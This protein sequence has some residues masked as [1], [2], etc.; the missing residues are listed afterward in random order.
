M[1]FEVLVRRKVLSAAADELNLT[2]STLSYQ[3]KSLEHYFDQR[4]F[5]RTREGFELTEYGATI[6]P[7]VRDLLKSLSELGKT[8]NAAR[9]Q[10]RVAC[11]LSIKVAWLIPRLRD[12]TEANPQ[13]D[14]QLI[15][16]RRN[17]LVKLGEA[18]VVIQYSEAVYGSLTKP[19]FLAE[20]VQVAASP[21]F[22]KKHPI[23]KPHD[24]LRVPLIINAMTPWTP[25]LR[26][27][28]IELP[29]PRRGTV[30]DSAVGVVEGAAFGIGAALI[31]EKIAE[32][33]LAEGRLVS[34]FEPLPDA[35]SYYVAA[36][37]SA[38]RRPEVKR[39][40]NWIENL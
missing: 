22:L 36:S 18:D 21:E 27:M 24:L 16:E 26:F 37:T 5:F 4:L 35:Y 23:K 34:I 25:W 3:I 1:A 19:R 13:I 29:E 30:I 31:R 6:V 15:S 28:G 32:R 12:F 14:I 7:T 39:F 40:L 17:D 9:R 8:E 11:P 38:A 33:A 2:P 10:V 20:S